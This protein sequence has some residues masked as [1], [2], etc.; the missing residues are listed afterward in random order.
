MVAP[1]GIYDP[2]TQ[3]YGPGGGCR[4]CVR[5][6][7]SRLGAQDRAWLF[8]VLPFGGTVITLHTPPVANGPRASSVQVSAMEGTCACAQRTVNNAD[9]ASR[10]VDTSVVA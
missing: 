4:S 7:G 8:R 5:C 2:M 6:Q 3:G 9:P 10:Q 1:Q